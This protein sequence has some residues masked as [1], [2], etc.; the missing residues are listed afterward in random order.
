MARWSRPVDSCVCCRLASWPERPGHSESRPRLCARGPHKRVYSQRT[1]GFLPCNNI[2]R[3]ENVILQVELS[4]LHN[5]QASG[6]AEEPKTRGASVGFTMTSSDATAPQHHHRRDQ[7]ARQ[8]LGVP[9]LL[10]RSGFI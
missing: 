6:T 5:P 7:L 1:P 2:Y 10:D 8:L 4:P 9:I 3:G